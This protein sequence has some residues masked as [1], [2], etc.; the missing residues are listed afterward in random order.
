MQRGAQRGGVARCGG[1]EEQTAQQESIGRREGR[2]RG[3]AAHRSSRRGLRRSSYRSY[4]SS[5]R[6]LRR[7]GLGL[8]RRGLWLVETGVGG[9]A[10]RRPEQ[11]GNGA[12]EQRP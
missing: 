8:R 10:A 7:R 6:G 2:G 12:G 9:D 4:R 3:A 11:G 5:Y 1:G